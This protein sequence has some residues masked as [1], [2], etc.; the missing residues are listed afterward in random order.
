MKTTYA[1]MVIVA[2]ILLASTG[3]LAQDDLFGFTYNMSLPTLETRDFISNESYRGATLEGRNFVAPNL[4]VGIS[5]GWQVFDEQTFETMNV[6]NGVFS[7]VVSGK[8]F[9][10]VN[11]V[12]ILANAYFYGGDQDGGRIFIGTGLGAYYVASRVEVGQIVI[13]NNNWHFG[14][15]PEFG[16]DF[17]FG[18]SR[19]L[20]SGTFNYVFNNE[21]T[22]NFS[23]AQLN[24]GIFYSIYEYMW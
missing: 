4:A 5:V 16:F 22:V 24:I 15:A 2:M 9:R 14:F 11:S 12:P 20:I 1:I 10:Y 17:P 8:Q 6:N 19:A 3:A 21:G 13:D 7:G 18:D 23:Y